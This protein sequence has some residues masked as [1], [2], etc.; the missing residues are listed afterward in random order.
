VKTE[1]QQC[2]DGLVVTIA[3]KHSGRLKS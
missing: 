3:A 2:V 1:S